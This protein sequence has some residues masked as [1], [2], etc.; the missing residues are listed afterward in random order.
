MA[1]PS[2]PLTRWFSAVSTT[3]AASA[4]ASTVPVSSGLSTGTLTT[5]SATP[6]RPSTRAAAS[7]GASI[8]PLANRATSPPRLMTWAWCSDSTWSSSKMTGTSP[9]LSRTYTGPGRSAMAAQTCRTSTASATSS[10]VIPG[11]ARISATSSMAW[12]LGPP[13]L[14][15][16]GMKPMIRTGSRG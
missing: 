8:M 3:R 16:P 10:T 4:T 7:A 2:P 1:V 13:G 12:W 9:R 11:T 14:E 6:W 15:M 5:D